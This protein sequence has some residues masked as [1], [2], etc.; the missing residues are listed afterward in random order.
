MG[1]IALIGWLPSLLRQQV[2]HH[3]ERLTHEKLSQKMLSRPTVQTFKANLHTRKA[4]VLDNLYHR[5]AFV[6]VWRWSK[7][8]RDQSL[9][10]DQ[11]RCWIECSNNIRII[12]RD[13]NYFTKNFTNYWCGKW[14][15]INEKVILMLSLNE[16]Q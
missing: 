9:R 3:G 14:L 15:L 4:I 1:T 6:F 13:T 2:E 8:A 10:L 12:A 11:L 5:L 7:L 16:N